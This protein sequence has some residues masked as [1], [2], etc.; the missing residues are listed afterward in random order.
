M[1][2]FSFVRSRRGLDFRG[3]VVSLN[4]TIFFFPA[5]PTMLQPSWKTSEIPRSDSQSRQSLT[6]AASQTVE[7]LKIL[8]AGIV[9]T[10]RTTNSFLNCNTMLKH[11]TLLRIPECLFIHM[12]SSLC[13]PRASLVTS[14]SGL[15]KFLLMTVLYLDANQIAQKKGWLAETKQSF[16]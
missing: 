9:S 7:H 15:S 10:A 12:S 11:L 2:L 16:F 13:I 14:C 5:P 6:S 1:T 8:W 3:A 4:A